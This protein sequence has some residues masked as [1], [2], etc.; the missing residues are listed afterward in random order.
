MLASRPGRLRL[1]YESNPISWI[2]EQAGGSAS[3]GEV[4]MLEVKPTSLHQRIG[5]VFGSRCEV[6]IIEDYY[7]TMPL[8]TDS[9]TPLFN[10]RGLFRQPG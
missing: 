10:V 2:V 5:F 8:D 4:R 3:T 6:A 9:D 1:L 7:H